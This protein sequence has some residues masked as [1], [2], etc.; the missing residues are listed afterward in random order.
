MS[1]RIAE[2]DVPAVRDAE[3]MESAFDAEYSGQSDY[4]AAKAYL[5]CVCQLAKEG[6]PSHETLEGLTEE[7]G[8]AF[9]RLDSTRAPV[10]S[11]GIR[12]PPR[13][14]L[15]ICRYVGLYRALARSNGRISQALELNKRRQVIHENL[16]DA[17]GRF[18]NDNQAHI[19]FDAARDFDALIPECDFNLYEMK[20]YAFRR[21]N[22]TLRSQHAA[23]AND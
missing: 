3:L 8:M 23:G 7:F 16:S 14:I 19:L 4:P 9:R 1:C 12:R 10:R 13:I 6:C 22:G 17:G 20:W 11:G 5:S 21:E 2:D 15:T 18:R